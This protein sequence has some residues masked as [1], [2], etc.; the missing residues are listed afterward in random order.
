MNDY[1]QL[2]K[3][4][5]IAIQY[6]GGQTRKAGKEPY[7]THI[8]SVT[9]FLSKHGANNTTLI[10][11]ILH[12]IIE[13]TPYTPEMLRQDFGDEVTSIV[14]ELTENKALSWEERKKNYIEHLK[15]ASKSAKMICAADKLDNLLS[16]TVEFE[17][18]GEEVWKH[19]NASKEKSIWFFSEVIKTL[20]E[21][22]NNPI[23]S[24]LEKALNNLKV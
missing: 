5:S 20:K 7:L 15:N 14:L 10:A 2:K 13:D 8:F 12:D 21:S 17:K 16:L 11:G 24:E 9:L 1:S 22:F 19:F 4:L 3:A 6:H 18:Q 23:V